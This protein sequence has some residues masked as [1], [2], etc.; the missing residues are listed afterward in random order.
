[1]D[2]IKC[3]EMNIE[4]IDVYNVKNIPKRI[5][6]AREYRKN[7]YIENKVE[8]AKYEYCSTQ[9]AV[10]K[11]IGV[12]RQTLVDWESG[13]KE[14]KI[15]NLIE[16]CKVFDCSMDYLLGA[17]NIPEYSTIIRASH[18]SGIPAE[19]IKYG[20]DNPDYLDC[21][22]FFMKPSNC[23]KLIKDITLNAWKEYWVNHSLCD[24]K[25][26]FAQKLL[27][28]YNEYSSLYHFKEINIGTYSKYL[29]LKFPE[30]HIV[31]ATREERK[32]SIVLK[33]C[34]TVNVYKSFFDKEV[35]KYNKF[36]KYLVDN[37][38]DAFR[39]MQIVE[40]EKRKIANSFIKLLSQYLDECE[41]IR[42][43]EMEP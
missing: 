32:N 34:F 4:G 29:K 11:K 41:E 3:I 7:Q 30:E 27:E 18:Y 19:I 31:F 26:A 13:K 8:Y 40:I 2:D 5:K 24:I 25:P 20:L 38:F 28:V 14:P 15:E 42:K 17:E 21:L 9:A 43:K 36:I 12:S 16:L 6:E 35:F 10:A 37:T 22:K 33:E 39:R 1:M 23:K